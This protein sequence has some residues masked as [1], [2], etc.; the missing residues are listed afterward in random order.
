M[1]GIPAQLICPAGGLC[2]PLA[3]VLLFSLLIASGWLCWRPANFAQNSFPSHDLHLDYFP[4]KK[5]ACLLFGL[6]FCATP[7]GH[8]QV[9]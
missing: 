9:I 6:K 1:I 7:H 5:A 4:S 3:G 8:F 2:S